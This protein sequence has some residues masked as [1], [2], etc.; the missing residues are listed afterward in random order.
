MMKR[1]F[2]LI[3]VSCAALL[4]LM[5]GAAERKVALVIGNNDYQN[6]PKLE[7]AVN[8]SVAVSRE[9]SKIGFEV[10]HLTNANQRRMNQGVNEFTQKIA[11]GGVGILYFAG[12]GVQINNQNFLLPVDMDAPKD[13]NDIDDQAI[14][15]IRVQDK[16]AD[17][18]AKFSLLVIDACRDNP[19]P[20]KAGRSIG[21]SKGLAQPASPNGQIVLFSAGANQQALDKLSD[22]DK[23]PNGL[24][25]REF[26]P[27]ISTPGVSAVEA[28][29]RVRSSVASKARSVGHEQ[30]P[31]LYDQTDGDFFFVAGP[32][33]QLAAAAPI[34]NTA[35]AVSQSVVE[36][37]FWSSIKN[38]NDP[39]D[40]KEYLSRYPNGQFASIA[41]RRLA[42]QSQVA[43]RSA[44]EA[45]GVAPPPAPAAVAVAP[46]AA[47]AAAPAPAP[48]AAA[49]PTI[50]SKIEQLG[51]MTYLRISDMRA[52]K[53]D[54]LLRI[55]F[56]VSNSSNKN[57]QMYYRFKWLDNDGFSVWNDEPW[58]PLIV[59]GNQKQTVN[60]VSPAFKA[61]DFR[62]VLQSPE[63]E[64]TSDRADSFVK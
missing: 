1:F 31:A 10:I 64:A 48:A 7:K 41:N 4:P 52:A 58:K 60:V 45:P 42:A 12:H 18:K 47:P 11:G 43:T 33:T 35:P 15:L 21:A 63:N 56:E 57:Q 8:D 39:E 20:K 62:L 9:L 5:A 6:V 26:L 30:N 3:L 13:P 37:E 22:N 54:G 32:A 44:G 59:Y 16:I 23:H 25:T 28:M 55:Q 24:F 46:M 50:A 40:F 2:A 19:L 36:V 53:R 27:M 38:S 34:Q 61:T 17:A 49:S 29:K 14:S 51:K